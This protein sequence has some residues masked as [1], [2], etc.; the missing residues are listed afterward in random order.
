MDVF[1]Q[2][3]HWVTGTLLAGLLLSGLLTWCRRLRRRRPVRWILKMANGAATHVPAAFG[4]AEQILLC[5]LVVGLTMLIVIFPQWPAWSFIASPKAGAAAQAP[6]MF[7]ASAG[8]LALLLFA[9]NQARSADRDRHTGPMYFGRPLANYLLVHSPWTPLLWPPAFQLM[10]VLLFALPTFLPLAP[11]SWTTPGFG[12]LDP[13]SIRPDGIV[14]ALWCAV[15]SITGGLLILY[16]TTALRTSLVGLLQPRYLTLR[17]LTDTRLREAEHIASFFSGRN[18]G[19]RRLATRDWAC[20]HIDRAGRLP[21][22]E[23]SDYFSATVLNLEAATL[24]SRT[25]T[26]A[27]RGLARLLPLLESKSGSEAAAEDSS[28]HGPMY[29]PRAKRLRARIRRSLRSVRDFHA[30]RIDACLA[31]LQRNDLPNELRMRAARL[32]LNDAQLVDDAVRQFRSAVPASSRQPNSPGDRELTAS[33][34]ELFMTDRAGM[35]HRLRPTMLQT[36]PRSEPPI[37]VISICAALYRDLAEA[38]FFPTHDQSHCTFLPTS[39]LV[40]AANSLDDEQTRRFA[41]AA[42][43]DAHIAC[44]TVH[45]SAHESRDI[46]E[47]ATFSSDRA[48]ALSDTPGIG[49]TER[50]ALS[51][52]LEYSA[53]RALVASP[54]MDPAA[55]QVLVPMVQGWRPYAALLHA[56]LY[57]HRSIGRPLSA[58]DLRPFHRSFDRYGSDAKARESAKNEVPTFLRGSQSVS[59]ICTDDG[60]AWLLDAASR[61]LS[62]SLCTEFLAE[63][64]AGRIVEFGLLQ[65]FQW[66]AVAGRHVDSVP[67]RAELDTHA[68]ARR[69]LAADSPRI[70]E[71]LQGWRAVDRWRAV[72]MERLLRALEPAPGSAR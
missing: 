46:D 51:E 60:V 47:L 1:N 69:R 52:L 38:V 9:A 21:A 37:Q 54:R 33:I 53:F 22:G 70:R 71:F 14:L 32:C 65:L 2:V 59:H 35:G 16:A 58:D 61:P 7:A 31:A 42:V 28:R 24:H 17:I 13:T 57:T 39:Q 25:M 26:T 41:V 34:G 48:S 64:E 30:G 4:S 10:I 72:D 67:S 23:S 11:A 55:R 20:G 43:M 36:G 40:D 29:E 45:R 3:A 44:V 50:P 8:L 66:H 15:F 68:V 49:R 6:T 18:D 63:C 62:L 12:P 19:Q 56:L 27:R 5:S